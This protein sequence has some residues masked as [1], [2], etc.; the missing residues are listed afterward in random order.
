MEN[1][2]GKI[3]KTMY[4]KMIALFF[5]M[6]IFQNVYTQEKLTFECEKVSGNVYCL[7]GAGGNIGICAT[8]QGN[9]I[10]DSQFMSVADTIMKIIDNISPKKIKYLVNTH[11]HADHTGGNDII[12]KDAEIIMHPD[13][14][15]TKK[16]LF[17][18][19]GI[20]NTALDNATV[21]KKGMNIKLGGEKINL[22]HFGNAH[23]SGDLIVVFETSKVIHPGDLFFHG[24]PPYI[25]VENGADTENWINTIEIL[26][27]R[28][29]DYKLI[30]GHGRVTDMKSF[31][32]FARY[33][34]IL[35]EKVAQAIK[36]GK[37]REQAMEQIKIEEYAHLRDPRSEDGLSIKR[38]IGWVYDEMM[39][40][41]KK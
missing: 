28:Y 7:Y 38:N 40:K 20:R 29:P 11:Y 36:L 24:W 21:W 35:R 23:T 10:V 37:T 27:K 33:L 34:K 1:N 5:I 32:D 6:V 14:K 31:S 22:L 30:P 16:N 19:A 8:D 41:E 9:L 17:K 15:S 25:D 4:K 2:S 13:C 39:Q 26:C 12:G 3:M 18:T